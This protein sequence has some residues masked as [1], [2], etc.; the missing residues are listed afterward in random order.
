MDN[1]RLPMPG[2]KPSSI[3]RPKF[4]RPGNRPTYRRPMRL[5]HL[6]IK[7]IVLWLVIGAILFGARHIWLMTA[8]HVTVLVNGQPVAVSTHRR[9]VEGAV[10]LAG[11]RLDE[12]VYVQPPA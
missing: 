6:P 2:E 1:R 12:T 3:W 10:R 5:P 4:Y 7:R 8:T 9:T 11:V